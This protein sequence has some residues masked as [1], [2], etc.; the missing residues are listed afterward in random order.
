MACLMSRVTVENE[1]TKEAELQFPCISLEENIPCVQ[2]ACPEEV[3]MDTDDD[4]NSIRTEETNTGTDDASTGIDDANTGID[5]ASTGASTGMGDVN[6]GTD[7]ICTWTDDASVT[8]TDDDDDSGDAGKGDRSDPGPDG[9]WGWMVTLAGFV[10]AFLVD[11]VLAC[12]GL[13]I[14]EL[15]T[16]YDAGMSMTSFPPAILQATYQVS[17][18]VTAY[19]VERWGCRLV[20]FCGGV[21]A[22]LGVAGSA[23]APNI[24]LF[25]LSFGVVAGVG[26]GLIY[27]PSVTMVNMYFHKKRGVVA[28]IITSGSGF[29]LLALAPLT[30]M[31]MEQYGWRGCYLIMAAITL[32]FCVCASLMRPLPPPPPS[33]T[34]SP[35]VLNKVV[36]IDG[37]EAS[38]PFMEGQDGLSLVHVQELEDTGHFDHPTPKA[39]LDGDGEDRY[40][41]LKTQFG[42]NEHLSHISL[43]TGPGVNSHLLN[44]AHKTLHRSLQSSMTSVSKDASA[45]LVSRSRSQGHLES[46]PSHR[47]HH[48]PLPVNVLSTW[49]ACQVPPSLSRHTLHSHQSSDNMARQSTGCG[50]HRWGDTSGW[51]HRKTQE[52]S[53]EWGQSLP[54][55]HH[56]V[57]ILRHV[58]MK[59]PM[60]ANGVPFVSSQSSADEH[61][62]DISANNSLIPCDGFPSEDPTSP[63]PGEER[64]KRG[65]SVGEWVRENRTFALF[66]TG[67]FLLQL[68]CNVPPL[69]AP[70]CAYQHGVSKEQVATILSIYGLLNTG[71]R[72]LA[73]V[74]VYMG[75]R[76]LHV[77]NLGT[78]LSA[79][80]CFVFPL[81][82]SFPSIAACLGLHGFFLGAFPPLQSVILVEYLGLERLT[83][84]FGIMCLVK[85]FASAAGPPLAGVLFSMTAKYTV[86]LAACGA[87]LVI[88]AIFHLLMDCRL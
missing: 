69:L 73:G 16:T 6:T 10:V 50:Q 81:A 24:H 9:G 63:E 54:A 3:N 75:M 30:E 38:C 31:L 35:D 40:P 26:V 52:N 67:A 44:P 62:T 64:R 88:A 53:T 42:K 70:S 85:A 61:H 87:V 60:K 17:G 65:R 66:L 41:P 48:T 56:T 68:V 71:G 78:L 37:Q 7:D 34:P 20:G 25:I 72:L 28:G 39:H 22:A 47:P 55:V 33:C 46:R 14:P 58:V 74:M 76:T 18:P 12:F 4:T 80:A 82:T 83:S 2:V 59:N 21:V 27:L 29:G 36:V 8:K 43:N 79:V 49:L 57:D 5:D 1:D 23:Y 13:V 84:T 51:H 19:L 45:S 11:G 15:L 32:H 77:Y 86:P